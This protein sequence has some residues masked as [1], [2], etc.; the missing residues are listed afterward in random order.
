MDE[1]KSRPFDSE[2][3]AHTMLE[4]LFYFAVSRTHD[5]NEASVLVSDIAEAVLS[6]LDRGIHPD[7]PQAWVWTIAQNRYARYVKNRLRD[8][9]RTISI[10]LDE[11]D[12]DLP[13]TEESPEERLLLSEEEAQKQ[14]DLAKLRETLA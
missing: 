13:D 11:G 6:A 5:E 14:K 3:F 2:I 7:D 1:Q 9:E 12:F 8:R 10:T 4:P